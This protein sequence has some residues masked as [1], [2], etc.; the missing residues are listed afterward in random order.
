MPNSKTF[1]ILKMNFFRRQPKIVQLQWLVWVAVFFIIYFSIVPEDGF[2]QSGVFTSISIAFYLMVIYGNIRF[3]YPRYYE[4]GRKVEYVIYVVIMVVGGG[5]LRGFTI[6]S[7]YN[8]IETHAE[9]MSAGNLINFI[10]AGFLIYLLSFVYRIAIAYF[11]LKQQSE[12]ILAQKSQ[13]ELN[14]LKSQVQPHFL[15]NTLN[16]IYYEAYR[17][18]PRTAKLIERLSDIM[19]YFVD[20]S[21]KDEVSLATEIQFL[22]NYIALEKIRI[23]HEIELNFIRECNPDVRIPPM[24]LMTFVE[25]IFKHG[26]DKSSSENKIEISLVQQDGYLLFQTRNRIYEIGG[27]PG[28]SGFGIENLRKRLAFLYGTRFELN[29]DTGDGYFTAFL[30]VPLA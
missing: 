16:N 30:K 15:F 18:A 25:N 2:V 27:V 12:K 9:K 24:L 1:V 20:E 13:A 26:I 28:G 11:T 23:R 10:V 4:T 17:E 14:L 21:P 7:I 3:L 22:E 8:R 5:A 29:I 19:R 6:I